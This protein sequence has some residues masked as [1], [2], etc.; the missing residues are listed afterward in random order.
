MIYLVFCKV[1][2]RIHR[3]ERLMRVR[4]LREDAFLKLVMKL[5]LHL[6]GWKET[7]DAPGRWTQNM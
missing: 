7:E 2:V 4:G 3:T 6:G 1:T 5:D